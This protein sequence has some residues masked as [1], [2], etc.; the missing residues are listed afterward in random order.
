MPPSTDKRRHVQSCVAGAA[1]GAVPMLAS[2]TALRWTL[3]RTARPDHLFSNVFDLQARA[4]LEGRWSLE[5][6]SLGI[7]SFNTNGGSHTYFPPFPAFIRMPF[8]MASDSWSGKLTALSMLAAWLVTMVSVGALI[9]T[10]RQAV[11]PGEPLTRRDGILTGG[12]MASVGGGSLLV[13]LA[14]APWVYHEVYAWSIALALAASL[15]LIRYLSS[16]SARRA[17]DVGVIVTALILTRTTLGAGL[18]ASCFLGTIWLYRR[19]RSTSW[20]GA[21]QALLLAGAVP[22][23]AAVA[24]TWI[25]FGSPTRFLP[26]ESQVWTQVNAHRRAALAA[27]GGGLTNLDFIPT[28]ASAYLNPFNVRLTG[29]FPFISLPARP[30]RVIGGAFFDQTYRAGSAIAFMPLFAVLAVAGATCTARSIIRRRELPTV[31]FP[32]VGLVVAI[33]GI[34]NYGYIAHRYNADIA[35]AMILA[36]V[37]AVVSLPQFRRPRWPPRAALWAGAGVLAVWGFVANGATAYTMVARTEEGRSLRDYVDRQLRWSSDSAVQRL[38]AASPTLPARART[39]TLQVVNGCAGLF[40][41]TGETNEPWMFVGGN[42]LSASVTTVHRQAIPLLTLTGPG[43]IPL[44]VTLDFDGRGSVRARLSGLF[45]RSGA[46]MPV[47]S[48]TSLL[49]VIPD[50]GSGN[51][52]ID[53]G[54]QN[55]ATIPVAI[56]D[57]DWMMRYLVPTSTASG[58]PVRWTAPVRDELCATVEDLA[59]RATASR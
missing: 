15:V 34:L 39:D 54:G 45:S 49:R 7:E 52:R 28:T 6:G 26:L 42:E 18:V 37:V 1:I 48:A 58:G 53:L 41:S 14:A 10:I 33:G 19:R 13:Y 12:L 24:V 27:N 2:L 50:V 21:W 25:K 5:L 4:L 30:P 9:W 20:G 29:Y 57:A 22:A 31:A 59:A 16:P 51:W 44:D 55:L 11:R 38:A 46:W 8:L 43:R 3:I 17:V 35:P 32:L 47:G 36:S 56:Y 40:L 23:L